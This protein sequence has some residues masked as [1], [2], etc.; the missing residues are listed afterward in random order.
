MSE[1]NID[2]VPISKLSRGYAGKLID[3]MN[4]SETVIY[5][6]RNNEPTAVIMSMK[7]YNEYL[8]AMKV[9]ERI[10]KKK[11]SIKIAGSLHLYAD[12]LKANE[13][14]EFYRKGLNSRYG[15]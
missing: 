10:N 12:P 1:R 13:E 4:E 11:N 6:L 2:Y 15:K 7:D 8:S 3:E 14:R 9:N 5:V